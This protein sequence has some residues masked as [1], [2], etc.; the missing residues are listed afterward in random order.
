MKS[1]WYKLKIFPVFLSVVWLLCDNFNA[2]C[3]NV[4]GDDYDDGDNVYV[5]DGNNLVHVP[6]AIR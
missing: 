5:V 6:S 2:N 3:D 1:L 4:V